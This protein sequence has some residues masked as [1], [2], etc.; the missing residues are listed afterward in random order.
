MPMCPSSSISCL[1]V[2]GADDVDHRQFPV[3]EGDNG[4]P[5]D[6][7]TLEQHEDVDILALRLRT[8]TSRVHSGAR[9]WLRTD[10]MSAGR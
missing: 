3:L 5:L 8:P 4:H 6:G 9:S 1:H 10:S 2:D 7:V